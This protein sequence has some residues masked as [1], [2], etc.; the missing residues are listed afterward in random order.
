MR[1]FIQLAG[2]RLVAVL[3]TGC[4]PFSLPLPF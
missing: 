2:L 1:R 4:M 3:L